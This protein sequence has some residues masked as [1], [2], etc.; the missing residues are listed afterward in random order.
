M[1]HWFTSAGTMQRL[2][3]IAIAAATILAAAVYLFPD[4]APAEGSYRLARIDRGEIIA[5]VNASGTINPTTTVI[6]GS[7]LSGQVVEI[8]AD[9]NSKVTAGQVVARLNSDQIRA[10]LDAARADLAQM[11]AQRQVQ[12]GMIEKVRADTEKARA[13]QADAEA[14]AARNEALLSDSER[15][16]QRQS[17]L[18]ARGY[19]AEQ[20]YDTA[21]TTRDAQ[22]AALNSARAQ[23]NS[24]KASIAGLA[25]DLRVA[26]ANFE[27]VG[28]QIM[29]REASVRQIEVDLRNTEIKSP[30]SG[31]VV[32]RN[33]ELGQTVAASLQ[34][35]TLFLIADDLHHMEIAANIDE[36]DVGRI[37][38]GLRASF[39]VT[40]YPGRSFEG[41]VKQVRLGS[42]TVQN[43]VI[44]TTIVSIE[45]P[46]LELLPGMTANLRI[47]T[48]RRSNVLR[49]PNAAL[50]WRPPSL[51]PE[52]GVAPSAQQVGQ[53]T[54]QRTGG[55]GSVRLREFVDALKS[56]IRLSAEQAREIDAAV[57]DMRKS[58]TGEMAA[59]GDAAERRERTRA[60]RQEFEQRIEATLTSEQRPAFEEIRKRFADTS[61]GRA[62]QTGRVFVSGRDGKPQGV[63][64]SLGASDGSVTEVLSGIDLNR[65]VIIGGAPRSDSTT[66][67]PRFGF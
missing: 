8:L 10:R 36:T 1:M 67:G 41:T 37:R 19:A 18:R 43:V 59:G 46:R 23:V 63:T 32:Q 29:Q 20:V 14:Q 57:A 16:F 35:P 26:Q 2:I 56:E 66:R 52:A 11:R 22:Q 42:Q 13:M 61:A 58:F 12:E 47:E 9:Y 40:A 49:V 64:L 15:I 28:A 39:T 34:S 3:A 24:A 6:V 17:E 45:N 30:V 50:R 4:G 33:V 5:T 27:A 48:E 53:P 60:L 62:A 51:A 65:E 44:Y 21:R 54:Q 31:V 25:A 38:E 55:N 7:Q